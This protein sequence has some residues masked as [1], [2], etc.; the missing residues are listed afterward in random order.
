MAIASVTSAV[1]LRVTRCSRGAVGHSLGDGAAYAGKRDR[2]TWFHPGFGGWSAAFGGG[3]DIV[4]GDATAG[5][6][7]GFDGVEID[8]EFSG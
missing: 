2:A 6:G 3:S 7:S 1:V 5:T 4:F 8:V